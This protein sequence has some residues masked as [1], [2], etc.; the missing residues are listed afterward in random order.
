M[1]FPALALRSSWESDRT[2]L[3]ARGFT[4]AAI[5][6]RPTFVEAQ[7]AKGAD[8]VLVEW[9]DP[10]FPRRIHPWRLPAGAMMECVIPTR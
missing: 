9:G 6:E 2:L 1:G 5:R 7:V 10:A 8:T 3:V 4:V